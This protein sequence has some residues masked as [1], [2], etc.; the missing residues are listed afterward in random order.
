MAGAAAQGA[1]SEPG[2]R[3]HPLAACNSLPPELHSRIGPAVP[4]TNYPFAG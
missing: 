2:A 1:A 4:A 3:V